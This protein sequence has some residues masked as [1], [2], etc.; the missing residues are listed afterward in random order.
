MKLLELI[1]AQRVNIDL[2]HQRLDIANDRIT[3]LFEQ[4]T[5]K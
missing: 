3:N 5:K 4:I 2:L 1:E